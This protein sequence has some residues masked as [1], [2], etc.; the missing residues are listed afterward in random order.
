MNASPVTHSLSWSLPILLFREIHAKV[1][2][3]TQ[4]RGRFSNPGHV[5]NLLGS[6]WWP[7]LNHSFAQTRRTFSGG[8]FG[9]RLST[10]TSTPSAFSTHSLPRPLYPASTHRYESRPREAR[11]G[12]LEQASD[13]VLIR[14][15]SRCELWPQ[16]PF[17]P[18][19]RGCG[20]S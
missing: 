9:E 1:R 5:G 20:A 4:R 10:S 8:G 6:I 2:S 12:R 3:A 14:T 15:P 18:Y 19:P 7:S 13:A 17:L 16:S 11:A